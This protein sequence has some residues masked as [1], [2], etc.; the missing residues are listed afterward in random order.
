MI[1]SISGT[2][3]AIGENTITVQVGGVGLLIYVPSSVFN[4]LGRIGQPVELVTHLVV[5]ED[6]LT[7]YGFASEEE[8]AIFEMLLGVSGVGPRLALAIVN[9]LAPN[10]LANAVQK[11]DPDIIAR[12]PGIG[13]KTAQKIVL[14]LKG[15]L[16]AQDLPAGLAAVSH[17]DTEVIEALTA[18]GFSLVEAQA[19]LQSIPRDAPDDLEERVR[20]ALAYFAE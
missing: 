7:L 8:K 14:E 20:L 2:L 11:D 1:A 16:V 10:V 17:A 3:L 18:M 9:T 6:S 19:A 15:K 5:R 13:K 12:V 4:K